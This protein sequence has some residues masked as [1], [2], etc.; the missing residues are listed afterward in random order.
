[1]SDNENK[2]LRDFYLFWRWEYVKRCDIKKLHVSG[3]QAHKLQKVSRA[4]DLYFGLKELTGGGNSILDGVVH[5][6]YELDIYNFDIAEDSVDYFFNTDSGKVLDNVIDGKID[7]I[8][9]R[10]EL[11]HKAAMPLDKV[12][13]DFKIITNDTDWNLHEVT[14]VDVTESIEKLGYLV[15]IN[16][17]A[18]IE[19]LIDEIKRIHIGSDECQLLRHINKTLKGLYIES[20]NGPRAVGLWLWDYIAGEYGNGKPP[21]GAITKAVNEL[22]KQFDL[23]NIRYADSNQKVLEDKYRGTCRCI[24][25]REVLPF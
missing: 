11:D 5:R 24:E 18:D 1:M 12:A 21:R 20:A 23:T 9:P 6:F 25:A 17:N 8:Y 22:R 3:I 2:K 16:R 4:K 15:L 19:T 13:S 7:Y 14:Q 10:I